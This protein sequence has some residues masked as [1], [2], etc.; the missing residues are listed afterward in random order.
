MV[1]VVE[2]HNKESLVERII[3]FL[4]YKPYYKK[5]SAKKHYTPKLT[6]FKEYISW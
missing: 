2:Y 4:Y 3:F 6:K 1:T 5:L